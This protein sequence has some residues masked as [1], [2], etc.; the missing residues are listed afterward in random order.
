M[1]KLQ[2]VR[3]LWGVDQTYGLTHYLPRWR[4]VGYEA[5]EVSINCVPDKAAFLRFLKESGMGWVPQV[6][7]NDFTPGGS[8]HEHLDS[9]HR[10]IEE[11]LDHAPLFFNAHTGADTWSHAQAEEFY[12]LALELENRIGIPISHETHRLRTFGIPWQTHR[13]LK[14]FPELRVTCDFSHWVC[15]CERLLPDLT[16]T[17]A[18]AA[19]HCYHVHSRVGFEEG[20]QVPD[21]SAPEYATHLAAHEAWWDLIWKSQKARGMTVS[22]LAPEFGPAP[23]MHML[24]HTNVPVADLASVCDWIAERQHR[25][26]SELA[27][28]FSWMSPEP[29]CPLPSL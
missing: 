1:M 14:S 23:Y 12:G 25:R 4:D 5:V 16:E 28:S 11:C 13:I 3:H 24:P 15:V 21:P 26:F 22:T 18:L 17:I 9:L 20:P 6:F 2:L 10:Q 19:Q 8:V 29:G 27:R 7:S